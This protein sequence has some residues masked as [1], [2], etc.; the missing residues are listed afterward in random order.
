[1]PVARVYMYIDVQRVVAAIY[2]CICVIIATCSATVRR[3]AYVIA[4]FPRAC[5]LFRWPILN[6]VIYVYI[7][8]NAVHGFL[9]V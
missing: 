8:T 1:M 4:M 5:N 6:N 3:D 9:N 7:Y 2:T